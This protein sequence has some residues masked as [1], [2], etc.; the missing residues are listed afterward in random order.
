MEVFNYQKVVVE[1]LLVFSW[2]CYVGKDCGIEFEFFVLFI[3]GLYSCIFDFYFLV[4][5]VDNL[6]NFV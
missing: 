4:V 2:V 5:L 6:L 1:S 3:G